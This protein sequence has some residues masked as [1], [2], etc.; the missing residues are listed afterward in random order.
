MRGAEGMHFCLFFFPLEVNFDRVLYTDTHT[1]DA[2]CRHEQATVSAV[3]GDRKS[4]WQKG[5]GRE[6]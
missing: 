2:S 1:T 5:R 3:G 4:R 6:N